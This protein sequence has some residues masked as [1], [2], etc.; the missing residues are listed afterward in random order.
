MDRTLVLSVTNWS[1]IGMPGF[2]FGKGPDPN[3]TGPNPGSSSG[4]G[5]G[6]EESQ[7][8]LRVQFGV[9]L[10]PDLSRTQSEPNRTPNV[11][12]CDLRAWLQGPSVV[13]EVAVLTL[14]I[15]ILTMN[16]QVFYKA[17]PANTSCPPARVHQSRR[18][19]ERRAPSIKSS[20]SRRS[21]LSRQ[22]SQP[23]D[24]AVVVTIVR[25]SCG[26]RHLQGHLGRVAGSSLC[27][28]LV[29]GRCPSIFVCHITL[30][31]ISSQPSPIA[32]F[33]RS[34]FAILCKLNPAALGAG[35][36]MRGLC[37]W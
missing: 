8:S 12:G 9:R 5:L 35:R 1:C 26:H 19:A 7:L 6:S 32:M 34:V 16:V 24:V 28:R 22:S 36:R 11:S 37:D 21:W 23:I 3:R 27:C 4:S 18:I 20:S 33:L 13:V 2:G 17:L 31:P 29:V 30:D 14:E 25:P 10:V 15:C